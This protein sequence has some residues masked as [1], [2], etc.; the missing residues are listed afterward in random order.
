LLPSPVATTDDH[1]SGRLVLAGAQPHRGLAPWCL[2]RH[3]GRRLPLA[4][5][6][7]MVARVH[8]HA[9]NLGAPAHMAAPSRLADVLVLV[10]Q[11]A[12]LSN[13]RH[14]VGAHPPHLPG[15]KPYRCH[16]ALLG[17]ELCRAARAPHD[18]A[19]TAG[20]HL[21]VVDLGSERHPSQRQRIADASLGILTGDDHVADP[22]AVGQEHVALVA[23][24]VVEEADAGR[25][26]RVVLHRRDGCGHSELV[27]LP[28][29][30]AVQALLAGALVADRQLPLAVAAGLADEALGERLVRLI[31][32]DLVEGR[33]R[34]LAQARAGGSVAAERHRYT[35][36]KSSIFCPGAIVTT[37]LRQPGT[38]PIV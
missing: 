12:D 13:R 24:G 7:W 36:S 11:V 30:D 29:D 14:A 38:V 28:V 2:R 15:R 20:D 23:I 1:L 6:V 8:H 17:E 9:A 26:V 3:P 21:D 31:G 25:T 22:Q 27:P 33:A 35:A 16:L 18:L 10:L 19:A 5:A 37:A 32:R 34:H 4:A